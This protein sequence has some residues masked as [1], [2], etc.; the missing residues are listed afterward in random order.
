MSNGSLSTFEATTAARPRDIEASLSITGDKGFINLGG[1]ALNEVC[2]IEY[3]GQKISSKELCKKYSEKVPNGYG[4]SHRYLIEGIIKKLNGYNNDKVVYAK[5]CISTTE[6][7]HAMYRSNE[8]NKWQYL[9]NK[10]LS[11]KL[12][13][14]K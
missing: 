14:K 11:L 1:I 9:N 12:G 4:L 13:L 5:D 3:Y 7:V 10:P 6:L 8:D 2:D